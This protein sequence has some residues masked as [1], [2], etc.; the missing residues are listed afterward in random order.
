MKRMN[1]WQWERSKFHLKSN[2]SIE[3]NL[4]KPLIPVWWDIFFFFCFSPLHLFTIRYCFYLRLRSL[5]CFVSLSFVHF[6]LRLF[7]LTC[8]FFLRSAK[9]W[10][11][12]TNSISSARKM[13][14]HSE[15]DLSFEWKK[16]TIEKFRRSTTKR[17]LEKKHTQINGDG[18]QKW[19]GEMIR[20]K[21]MRKKIV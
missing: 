14:F 4:R 13:I 7:R 10:P 1:F 6:A 9:Q 3:H 12:T 2:E 11:I 8:L 16:K 5:R 19:Q 18:Q 15:F 20:H 17:I 21:R